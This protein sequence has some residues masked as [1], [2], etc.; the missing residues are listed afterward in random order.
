MEA[1]LASDGDKQMNEKVLAETLQ[2]LRRSIDNQS[3]LI[4][5]MIS[6]LDTLKVAVE[7]LSGENRYPEPPP[8]R[9]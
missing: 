7:L 6:N 3:R 1:I 5:V 9:F 4:E 8:P 2:D